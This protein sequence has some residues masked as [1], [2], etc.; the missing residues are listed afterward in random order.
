[1]VGPLFDVTQI[2]LWQLL[3]LAP[4]FLL[5]LPDRRHLCRVVE[6]VASRTELVGGI[7]DSSSKNIRS[8]LTDFVEF[9]LQEKKQLIVSGTLDSSNEALAQMTSEDMRFL[10]HR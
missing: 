6:D 4:P 1:M 9:Q 8:F 10:F 2:R 3:P 5:L 7:T